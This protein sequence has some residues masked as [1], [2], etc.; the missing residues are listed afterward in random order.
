MLSEKLWSGRNIVGTP[1][2]DIR[3]TICQN[4]CSNHGICNSE[5]RACMCESFWMPSLYYFWGISEANCG[6]NTFNNFY[7]N[8]RKIIF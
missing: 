6:M 8:S 5:T 4:K 7:A 3:T 1:M 2:S